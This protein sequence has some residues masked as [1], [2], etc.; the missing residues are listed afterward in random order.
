MVLAGE[1]ESAGKDV[2]RFKKGDQV[3]A[4]TVKSPIQ[5]RLALMPSTYACLEDWMV[6]SK[7]S[8]VTYDEAAAIPYGGML[9]LHFSE[10]RKHPKRTKMFLF[11]DL[12]ERSA[13][14][15]YSLPGTLEQRVTGVCGAANLELVKSLGADTVIDYT[16]EDFYEPR[17]FDMILSLML[18]GKRKASVSPQSRSAAKR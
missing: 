3:F 5:M 7:P 14:L 13:Q 12:P 1:V 2:Q 8:N 18:L 11:M 6:A 10:E 4:S 9:A 15:Q 17:R 16:Q